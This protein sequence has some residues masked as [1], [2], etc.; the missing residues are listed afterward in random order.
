MRTLILSG[1]VLAAC[2]PQF[3]GKVSGYGLQVKDTL[4]A[5]TVDNSGA[6]V[7]AVLVLSD[8]P[9][10]CASLAAPKAPSSATVAAFILSRRSDGTL[11]APDLGDYTV[12]A[13]GTSGAAATGLFIHTD[14]NGTNV[15]PTANRAAV[16]GV[17]SISTFQAGTAMS[18]T[19]DGKFGTQDDAIDFAFNAH[20]CA[21]DSTT[22]A[23]G[24]LGGG[25]VVRPASGA[26]SCMSNQTCVEYRGSSYTAA[27]TQAGCNGAW[28][29]S[30]CPTWGNGT[31]VMY[32]GTS[33][34]YAWTS[35]T[36][37]VVQNSCASSGGQFS[38]N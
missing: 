27:S 35:A 26:G 1:L 6:A 17:L 16:S 11:L 30:G 5:T 22:I 2:G 18:G 37:G 28:S 31:C 32:A 20:F 34:E 24:F 21:I 36:A 4:F 10:M 8:Q 14:A 29:T 33:T 3:Q 7:G 13:A 15:I 25:A 38:S 9:N 12:A 23:A 19:F